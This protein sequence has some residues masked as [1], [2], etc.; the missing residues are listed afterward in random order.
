MRAWA[1]WAASRK[2]A[3]PPTA[4]AIPALATRKPATPAAAAPHIGVAVANKHG[5]IR[6]EAQ[7]THRALDHSRRWLAAIAAIVRAV[8]TEVDRLQ[9]QSLRGQHALEPVMNLFE[10]GRVEIPARETSHRFPKVG[11]MT[12]AMG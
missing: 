4:P 10:P 2:S 1:R 12:D 6:P 8:R 3:A 5:L 11:M 9:P 7:I